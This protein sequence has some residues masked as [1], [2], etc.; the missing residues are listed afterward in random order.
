MNNCIAS[1]SDHKPNTELFIS[2]IRMSVKENILIG[3]GR[4]VLRSYDLNKFT[5]NK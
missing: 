1:I 5:K 2:P 3:G 4:K